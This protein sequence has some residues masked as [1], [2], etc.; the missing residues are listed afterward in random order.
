MGVAGG[1][2]SELEAALT[3]DSETGGELII[4][5]QTESWLGRIATRLGTGAGQVVEGVTVETIV[6]LLT[7]LV[8][9]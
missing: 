2:I 4:G 6:A 7:K 9:A 3:A 1:R 5:H 8:A